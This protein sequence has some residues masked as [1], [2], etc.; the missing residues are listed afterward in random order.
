ME[1]TNKL[2]KVWS[3]PFQIVIALVLL[4]RTMGPSIGAGVAV[5]V[6]AVPLNTF[7]ARK[8][9]TLQKVQM[10]NKD[11]RVKLMNEVLNGIRVIKLYAWESP[12][13][14]KVTLKGRGLFSL[15]YAKDILDRFHS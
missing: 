9:R 10:G 6:L 2:D 13:L 11:A 3:G 12:F 4:Y 5:L 7:L 8:M 1:D 15:A 14:E